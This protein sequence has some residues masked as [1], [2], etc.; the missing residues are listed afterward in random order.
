MALELQKARRMRATANNLAKFLALTWGLAASLLPACN[1]E[2]GDYA[3]EESDLTRLAISAVTASGSEAGNPPSQAVDGDLTTRWSNF[4]VGSWIQVDLGASR[5]IS[6]AQIAWYLGDQ[7]VSQFQISVSANGTSFTQLFSGKSSGTTTARESYSFAPVSARYL[8][9]TVNGNTQNA[10][11]SINELAV[12]ADNTPPTIAIT[13]PVSGAALA[14][15]SILVSGTAS[16]AGG[17]ALVELTLDGG[18]YVSATPKASGDWSSWSRAIAVAAGSHRITARATDRAGNQAWFSI[19]NSYSGSSYDD[20]VLADA[21]VGFWDVRGGASEADLTG[22]GHAGSYVNG[23]PRVTSMPNGDPAADFDGVKQYLTIPSS[24]SFSIP[25]TQRLTWEAWIRPDV[26]EFPNPVGGYADFLGKCEEYSPTCEWEGRMYTLTNSQD[27]GSRISGY[28]F[29]PSADK[30]SS[31]D[32]QPDS[33]VIRAGDWHHVVVEYQTVSTPAGCADKGPEP[34]G[35]DIWV[36]GVKWSMKDHFPTGCMSQYHVVPA[37]KSSPINIGV[38]VPH[39]GWFAGAVGKF[40]IY[41]HLLT[42]SQI[43]HHFTTMT[44]KTP[45]GSCANVCKL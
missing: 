7:R 16:D 39:E 36:D 28:V 35:I 8:R 41:D 4:G 23:A 37:A 6:G 44:G 32:W 42:Q 38:M 3:S 2:P 12:L 5:A 19:T 30:G 29:N 34:G 33:G 17:I 24:A 22:N 45:S 31:A 21:P 10:W 25:T 20:I 43:N 1:Y 9:V 11:A 13:A 26:L 15:G 14:A 18:A 27:R 40:A